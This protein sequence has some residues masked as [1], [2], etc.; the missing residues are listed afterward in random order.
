MKI[1][2]RILQKIACSHP[3]FL[4]CKAFNISLKENSLTRT[5]HRKGT[6]RKIA[7]V[8]RKLRIINHSERSISWV[9][10][11]VP[12]YE[13][14]GETTSK[15][16]APSTM[17][18]VK[19]CRGFRGLKSMATEKETCYINIFH[20]FDSFRG[21]YFHKLSNFFQ[22]FFISNHVSHRVG[23]S[24]SLYCFLYR[25]YQVSRQIVPL[26]HHADKDIFLKSHQIQCL[27]RG[28][29]L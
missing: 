25:S 15:N 1:T 17:I 20:L 29:K 3:V 4:I 11:R 28:G 24:L 14:I 26:K 13:R 19:R 23:Y 16:R 5:Y 10:G 18:A 22:F 9:V 2:A 8:I 6:N 12:I 7:I 27:Y 21:P